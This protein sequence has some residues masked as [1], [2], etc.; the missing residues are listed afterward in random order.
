M[1]IRDLT[2]NDLVHLARNRHGLALAHSHW[3]VL[4]V[5]VACGEYDAGRLSFQAGCSYSTARLALG[6]VRALRLPRGA[7]RVGGAE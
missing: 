3:R 1:N 5:A 7:L 2:V 4:F 6:A